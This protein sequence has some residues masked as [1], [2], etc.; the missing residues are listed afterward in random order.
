MLLDSILADFISEL[1]S[2]R[3]LPTI[4]IGYPVA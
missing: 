4:K 1:D 2:N 3:I